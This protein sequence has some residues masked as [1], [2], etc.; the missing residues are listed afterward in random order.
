[1]S[2]FFEYVLTAFGIHFGIEFDIYL[3]M[4]L[5]FAYF[6]SFWVFIQSLNSYW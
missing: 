5:F 4:I 1:M 2:K 3:F 6:S